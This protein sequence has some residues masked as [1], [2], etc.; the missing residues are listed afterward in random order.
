MK[1]VRTNQSHALSESDLDALRR[2]GILKKDGFFSADVIRQ[3]A[4][5]TIRLRETAQLHEKPSRKWLLTSPFHALIRSLR[6]QTRN[7]LKYLSDVAL[8]CGFRRFSSLYFGEPVRLSH[9]MSIESPVSDEPITCWHTDANTVP[10]K[11]P[12]PPNRFTLKC[13]V[14]LNDIDSNNGAFAYLPKS[15]R[16]VV[17]IRECIY[18]RTLPFHETSEVEEIRAACSSPQVLSVVLKMISQQDIDDFL[19]TTEALISETE[20]THEHDLTGRAGTLL[21]FDD[22]GL[23]RGGIP[24]SSNRSILRYNYLPTQYWNETLSPMRYWLYMGS[25]TLLPRSVAAHW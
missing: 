22:R 10:P 18:N 8:Q 9:I 20:A 3:I 12:L 4:D 19:S 1:E 17:A 2:N 25:L 7:D 11:L 16:L 15:H 6:H 24:K 5:T 14:Y 13:F 23:H 21:I